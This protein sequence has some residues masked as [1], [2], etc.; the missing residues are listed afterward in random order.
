MQTVQEHLLELEG[1][2]LKIMDMYFGAHWIGADPPNIKFVNFVGSGLAI[3]GASE[4]GPNPPDPKI[5]KNY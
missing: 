5:L 2:D 3:Q 1:K 4:R